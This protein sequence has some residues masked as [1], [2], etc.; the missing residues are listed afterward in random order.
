MILKALLTRSMPP[1]PYEGS[2]FRIV[3]SGILVSMKQIDVG[4]GA[5]GFRLIGIRPKGRS[6]A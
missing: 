3:A 1:F 4:F 5:D 6:A 2:S